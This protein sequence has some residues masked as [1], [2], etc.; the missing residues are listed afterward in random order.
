MEKQIIE[1][2]KQRDEFPLSLEI[3]NDNKEGQPRLT[4]KIR[5]EASDFEKI[6]SDVK[7]AVELY[8]EKLKELSKE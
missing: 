1:I 3:S 8:K 4:V 2:V 6:K 5:T 7:A